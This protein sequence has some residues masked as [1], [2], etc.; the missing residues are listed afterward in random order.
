MKTLSVCAILAGISLAGAL[1]G[2]T[3]SSHPDEVLDAPGGRPIA[4]LLPGASRHIVEEKDGYLKVVVEGWIRSEAPEAPGRQGTDPAP[5]GNQPASSKEGEVSSLA[6][7]SETSLSGRIE[8]RLGSGE[9]RYG[10]GA[11]VLALGNVAEL[12]ARR[13]TLSTAYRSESRD[14]QD[15]IQTL[16]AEKRQALNSSDNLA[17]A[18]Q[19]LD[20]A[21]V[22]LDKASKELGSLQEKYVAL[23]EA[24]LLEFKVA[25]AFADPGGVYRMVGL[26]PG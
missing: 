17:Q 22:R 12:E 5:T 23:G 15:Q 24:L 6:S 10:A 8:I 1:A 2:E 14:L 26:S 20:R 19:N 21:K 25:E 18:T 16:E 3:P 11:R 7:P 13:S 4:I 9:I